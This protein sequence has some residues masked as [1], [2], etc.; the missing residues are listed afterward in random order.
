MRIVPFALAAALGAAPAQAQPIELP[1]PLIKFSEAVAHILLQTAVSAARS[2][3]EL[4]Y[5]DIVL[6]LAAGRMALKGL[7]VR[8]DLPWVEAGGCAASAEAIEFFGPADFTVSTGRVEIIGLNLPL[9]CL[10]PDQ[11]GMIAAAGYDAVRAASLSVDFDYAAGPSTLDFTIAATLTDAVALEAAVEFDY[12]WVQTPGPF[13]DEFGDTDEFDGPPEGEPVADLAFAEISLDDIGLLERAGPMLG[14]M[15][16]GF[17]AV[18]LMIEGGI[19]QELGPAAQPFAVEMRSAVE[20][21]LSG[22]EKLVLTIA[23][24]APIRLTPGLTEDSQTL[25]AT[26]SPSASGQTAASNALIDR[27]LLEAAL[28]T[29]EVSD[30][31]RLIVGAALATGLGAP[32]APEAARAVLTPLVEALDPEAAL[33][34]SESYGYDDL[35]AAYELALVAAAG[36]ADGALARL[37]RLETRLSYAALSEAQFAVSEL[38]PLEDAGALFES[39]DLAAM[40]DLAADLDRGI[41]AP[42]DYAR[43]YVLAALAAAGGD[44]GAAALMKRIDTLMS[45]RGAGSDGWVKDRADASEEAMAI[46]LDEGLVDRLAE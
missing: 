20:G 17:E 21:F 38:W 16:G 2:Q 39:G 45:R 32:K 18:P 8:P 9:A 12:F 23:P 28:T 44:R 27:S 1:Q 26:L 30:E 11:Q 33:I 15:I 6:D 34:A 40:R 41:G 29:G 19:L 43:A 24:D 10:P 36:G 7:D 37:D 3:V 13:E 46:W 42:R 25:F 4:T 5:D 22:E 31:E 14:A 35:Q